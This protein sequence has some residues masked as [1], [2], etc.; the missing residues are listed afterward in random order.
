MPTAPQVNAYEGLYHYLKAIKA[1]G[2]MDTQVVMKKM[3][4]LKVDDSTGASGYFVEM[5]A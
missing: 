1:A 3:K 2:T 4:E 5:A